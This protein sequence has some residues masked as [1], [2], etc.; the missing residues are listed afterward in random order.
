MHN[1]QHSSSKWVRTKYILL[2]SIYMAGVVF[3]LRAVPLLFGY[4]GHNWA[5]AFISIPAAGLAVASVMLFFKPQ[6]S[7]SSKWSIDA[8]QQPTANALKAGGAVTVIMSVLGLL[9]YRTTF[10]PDALFAAA[11]TLALCL[12]IWATLMTYL[13]TNFMRNNPVLLDQGKDGRQFSEQ[14]N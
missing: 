2:Y 4:T 9:M 14:I 7:T 6:R 8:V 3:L 12:G 13:I 1:Q 10:A 11:S 5:D